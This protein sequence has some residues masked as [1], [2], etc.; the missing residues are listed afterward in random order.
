MKLDKQEHLQKFCQIVNA[1]CTTSVML[2]PQQAPP[3][4]RALA[5]LLFRSVNADMMAKI[6]VDLPVTHVATGAI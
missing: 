3:K 5:L 4:V 6:N 1:K 2:Y